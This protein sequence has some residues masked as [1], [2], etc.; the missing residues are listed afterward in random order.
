MASE[1]RPVRPPVPGDVDERAHRPE[2]HQKRRDPDERASSDGVGHPADDA[3][4]FEPPEER[5]MFPEEPLEEPVGSVETIEWDG[6]D[7]DF[8]DGLP[9]GEEEPEDWG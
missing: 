7:D 1:R 4:L 3:T 9:P 8:G 6:G 2:D 5:T